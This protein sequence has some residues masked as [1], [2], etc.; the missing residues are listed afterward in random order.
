MLENEVAIANLNRSSKAPLL[1]TSIASP[2]SP[3]PC[4]GH[5]VRLIGKMNGLGFQD[6][7]WLIDCDGRLLQVSEL[8]YRVA[9]Q[10]NGTRNLK[11]IADL[12]SSCTEWSLDAS[13]VEQLM[14]AKLIPLGIIGTNARQKEKQSSPLGINVKF[15]TLRPGFIEPIT[16]VLRFLCNWLI[17]ACVLLAS[18]G[19]HW[20]LYRIHGVARGVEDAIYTPGGVL[21]AIGIVLLAAFFHEFGH[22]SALRHHGGRVGNMGLALYIIYPALYTDVTDNYRLSRWARVSTDLG[23]IYF[24]LIFAL[25]LFATY[26]TTHRELYLFSVLLIDLAIIEQFIPVIRLDGYWLL[27]DIT[28]IPDFFS[29]MGPFMSRSLPS[30]AGQILQDVTGTPA[31]KTSGMPELKPWVKVV[32]LTYILITVPLLLYVFVIMIISLPEL[33]TTAW[34]GLQAQIAMLKTLNL[35]HDFLIVMLVLLQIVFLTL[36]VPATIYFLWITL[37]PALSRLL[38]WALRTPRNAFAGATAVLTCCGIA[39]AFVSAPSL[40]VFHRQDDPTRIASS[41]IHATQKTTSQLN[42][43]TAD[44]EG[45]LGQDTY[46][47]T[48]ML[49]RPNLARV[50]INGTAGLGR[51]LLVSDG[52]TA[53]TYFRDSNQFVQVAPGSKGDFIQSTVIPQVEQFFR[54]Q[55]MDNPAGFNYLGHR[56]NDGVEYDVV[57]AKAASSSDADVYYFV[58]RADTL[59]QRVVET[60]KPGTS[61]T[62]WIRL[63]NVRK[64]APIDRA[65]FRW[66]LPS[67]AKQVQMPVGVQLPVKP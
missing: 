49:E 65:L 7:Q 43:M 39:F 50:E 13:D 1:T 26:F 19:A 25:A 23:G 62:T 32:F 6:Q 51:L 2:A 48:M 37:K 17:V 41:L 38:D 12:V 18:A 10:A 63:K 5:N 35:R 56:I 9:E 27:C 36:P 45:S 8:L 58:S 30:K 54:P 66:R 52:T 60:A 64:N 16:S 61:P 33:L 44:F 14:Q 31:T 20:W 28:G 47:G 15:R 53:T 34:G 24:H 42:S 3:A 67:T 11:Q 40:R 4:I 21:F 29:Y 55:S 22:A 57:E 59:I 46:T